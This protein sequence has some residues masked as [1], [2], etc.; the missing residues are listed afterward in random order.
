VELALFFLE[1]LG[2]FVGEEEA[3]LYS[4]SRGEGRSD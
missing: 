4:A 3:A 2:L 1:E